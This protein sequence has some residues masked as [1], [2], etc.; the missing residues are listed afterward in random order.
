MTSIREFLKDI[1]VKQ[2]PEADTVIFTEKEDRFAR[3]QTMT[4]PSSMYFQPGVVAGNMEVK[5]PPQMKQNVQEKIR[6]FGSGL[7]NVSSETAKLSNVSGKRQGKGG[8]SY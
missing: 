8:R 1:S 5:A 4:D 3:S 7:E 2:L 6:E